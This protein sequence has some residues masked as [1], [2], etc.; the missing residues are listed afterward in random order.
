MADPTT[1]S[2]QDRGP[3]VLAVVIALLC[4]STAFILIRLISRIGVVKRVSND[5][6]AIIVAWVSHIPIRLYQTLP[7]VNTWQLVAFGFSF[8]I[9]YGTRV[10]LGRHEAN[11]APQ[12]RGSLRKAEYAFSVLY[13]C[14]HLW[15]YGRVN[16]Y[17]VRTRH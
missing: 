4:V 5:D 14:G 7:V 3:T 9:C 13:V 12:D 17:Y 15:R 1:L 2:M 10:G 8:S 11:I 6:Y 16:A